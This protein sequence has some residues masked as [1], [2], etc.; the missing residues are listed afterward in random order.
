MA[1][2]GDLQESL[3]T[4][5]DKPGRERENTTEYSLFPPCQESN[6]IWDFK[7]FGEFFPNFSPIKT[8]Q[9]FQIQTL[10]SKKFA[11]QMLTS[12]NANFLGNHLLAGI[13]PPTINPEVLIH[14]FYLKGPF[15][16]SHRVWNTMDNPG[17]NPGEQR[18]F[19][20]KGKREP[21]MDELPGGENLELI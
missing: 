2:P 11:A 18:E 19:G 12:P 3:P 7:I 4:A 9:L 17:A 15:L 14:C 10:H 13:P 5:R 8:P 16:G 21:G 20:D 6:K 1:L